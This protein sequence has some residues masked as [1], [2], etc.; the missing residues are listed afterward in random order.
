MIERKRILQQVESLTEGSDIFL[1]DVLVSRDT[2]QVFVDKPA[3][4]T[5]EDCSALSGRLQSVMGNEL[6]EYNLVVS[7]PGLDHPL[8]IPEQ[9]IRNEGKEVE[10]VTADGMKRRGILLSADR[11]GFTIEELIK[12]GGRKKEI[13]G[14]EQ[15]FEYDGVKRVNIIVKFK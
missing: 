2:V 13:R 12:N 8:K 5:I 3:G 4:I 14:L 7:S 6:D 10:V 9:F 11:L 15:R 1:V